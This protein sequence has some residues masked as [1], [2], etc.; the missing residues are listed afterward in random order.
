MESLGKASSFFK[1]ENPH[2]GYSEFNEWL[3]EE[4]IQASGDGVVLGQLME[5]TT[6][7]PE[8]CKERAKFLQKKISKLAEHMKKFVSTEEEE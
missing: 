2:Y 6:L 3:N 7:T 4:V 8:D 5:C 1:G